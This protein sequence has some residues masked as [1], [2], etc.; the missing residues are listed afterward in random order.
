[1]SLT[2]IYIDVLYSIMC[3]CTLT[4]AAVIEDTI[5]CMHGGLSPDLNS[6]NQVSK[7]L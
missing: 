2:F 1:M 5:L 4:L 6:L 3:T 7:L